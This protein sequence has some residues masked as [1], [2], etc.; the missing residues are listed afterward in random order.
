[1]AIIKVEGIEDIKYL[2]EM[3][4]KG[5]FGEIYPFSDDTG[6]ETGNNELLIVS[7]ELSKF[8]E[9]IENGNDRFF[10]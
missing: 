4:N 6:K 3:V 1:M 5:S 9:A 10:L 7:K 2:D 8:I